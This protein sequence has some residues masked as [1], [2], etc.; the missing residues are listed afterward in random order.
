[1]FSINQLLKNG[2]RLFLFSIHGLPVRFFS[3]KILVN[4]RNSIKN[5]FWKD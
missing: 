5:L 2:V 3:D 4:F 1:M